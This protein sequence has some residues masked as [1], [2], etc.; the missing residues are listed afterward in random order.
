MDPAAQLPGGRG[1][2]LQREQLLRTVLGLHERSITQ[3]NAGFAVLQMRDSE[4]SVQA[5]MGTVQ[6]QCLLEQLH[7]AIDR[8]APPAPALL[9]RAQVALVGLDIRD[10][11]VAEALLIR[12]T[13]AQLQGG[14]D[15]ARQLLLECKYV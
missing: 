15:E 5:R 4:G 14:G 7:R 9:T 11:A 1:C 8:L 6:P 3:I 12:T 2:G 10:C 13:Q